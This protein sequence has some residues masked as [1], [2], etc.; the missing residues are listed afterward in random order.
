[1]DAS[2]AVK[3]HWFSPERPELRELLIYFTIPV[4]QDT[5]FHFVATLFQTRH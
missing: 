1:L 5:F 2:V 4:A 3:V